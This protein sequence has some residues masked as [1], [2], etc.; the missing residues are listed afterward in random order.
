MGENS[1]LKSFEKRAKEQ[2]KI[3]KEIKEEAKYERLNLT[4]PSEHKKKLKEYCEK[5]YITPA[6]FFRKCIDEYC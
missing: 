2:D 6:A 1:Y 4:I 5:N 3:D